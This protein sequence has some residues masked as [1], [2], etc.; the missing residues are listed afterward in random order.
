M[1]H[2]SG[3]SQTALVMKYLPATQE[4]QETRV[5]SL[6]GEDPLEKKMATHSS[7][8]PGTPHGQRSLAGYIIV[9]RAAESDTTE[10]ACTGMHVVPI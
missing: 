9:H 10:D 2:V 4:M 1:V 6:G 5:Q 7:T 3:A 8:L